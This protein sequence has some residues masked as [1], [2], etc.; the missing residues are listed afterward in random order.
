M[1][2]WIMTKPGGWTAE[3]DRVAELVNGADESDDSAA[4]E[5]EDADEIEDADEA[6]DAGA[7]T[8]IEDEA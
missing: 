2:I 1:L 7:D 5:A 6:E 3:G 4:D 8:D